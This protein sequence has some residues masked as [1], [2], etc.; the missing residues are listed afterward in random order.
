MQ[1][2]DKTEIS[3]IFRVARIEARYIDCWQY[4]HPLTGQYH[5][6]PR[7]CIQGWSEISIE[8]QKAWEYLIRRLSSDDMMIYDWLDQADDGDCIECLTDGTFRFVL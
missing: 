3:I 4:R 5:E 6:I 1:T 7:Q 8:D 2:I